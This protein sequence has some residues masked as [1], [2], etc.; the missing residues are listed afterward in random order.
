MIVGISI[1]NL[2]F[3]NVCLVIVNFIYIFFLF[4]VLISNLI[5]FGKFFWIKIDLGSCNY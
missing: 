2:N 1:F 4:F 5:E 3:R